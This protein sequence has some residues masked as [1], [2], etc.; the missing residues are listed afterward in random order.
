M[1]FLMVTF[2]RNAYSDYQIYRVLNPPMMVNPLH[3]DPDSDA[4]LP[5]VGSRHNIKSVG[6]PRRKVA[7]F[8]LLG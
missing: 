6:L 3:H 1:G 2:R 8:L 4:F 5:S 7:S